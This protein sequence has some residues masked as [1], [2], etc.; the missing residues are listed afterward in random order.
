MI[1]PDPNFNIENYHYELGEHPFPVANDLW[2]G[3]GDIERVKFYVPQK[4]AMKDWPDFLKLKFDIEEDVF[5]D[6][7]IVGLPSTLSPG[8]IEEVRKNMY[9]YV[10]KSIEDPTPVSPPKTLQPEDALESIKMRILARRSFQDFNKMFGNV[11]REVAPLSE[12]EQKVIQWRKGYGFLVPYTKMTGVLFPTPSGDDALQHEVV[13]E[14]FFHIKDSPLSGIIL[15]VAQEP[16]TDRAIYGLR[17]DMRTDWVFSDPRFFDGKTAIID[18]MIINGKAKGIPVDVT[19]F[20][21]KMNYL[22]RNLEEL[23]AG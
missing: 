7:A 16:N 14:Y 1:E 20:V 21:E 10:I 17:R 18:G 3:L 2:I 6:P 15:S 5:Y 4:R 12:W 13:R 9:K 19:S 23:L 22:T 11:S 8:Q